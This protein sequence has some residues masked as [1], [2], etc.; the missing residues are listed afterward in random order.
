MY[1]KILTLSDHTADKDNYVVL[2]LLNIIISEY[3]SINQIKLINIE[4]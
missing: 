1:F 4:F 2:F 3:I